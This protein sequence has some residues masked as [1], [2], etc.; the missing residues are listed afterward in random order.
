M[1][2][3]WIVMFIVIGIELWLITGLLLGLARGIS[4]AQPA[5]PSHWAITGEVTGESFSLFA[6]KHAILWPIALRCKKAADGPGH[7]CVFVRYVRHY[8]KDE[9]VARSLAVTYGMQMPPD[10]VPYSTQDWKRESGFQI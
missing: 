8:T 2:L 3:F 1:T 9:E 7:W 10:S 6:L 4:F 5:S